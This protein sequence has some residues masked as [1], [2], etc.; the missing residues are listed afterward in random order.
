MARSKAAHSAGIKADDF[1]RI[2]V[3]QRWVSRHPDWAH[4]LR[5]DSIER[6]EWLFTS[7]GFPKN[8]NGAQESAL[9]YAV[10]YGSCGL[11]KWVIKTLKPGINP[12]TLLCAVGPKSENDPRGSII[13]YLQY[14]HNAWNINNLLRRMLRYNRLEVVQYMNIKCIEWHKFVKSSAYT[15]TTNR[16]LPTQKT[17]MNVF[18]TLLMR[19]RDRIGLSP[20]DEDDEYGTA[21]AAGLAF[22]R[23]RATETKAGLQQALPSDV[24]A[25]VSGYDLS[26]LDAV[27]SIPPKILYQ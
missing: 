3:L 23:G 2:V 4:A 12:C 1:E 5:C 18:M 20:V 7:G 22:L 9:D 26:P 24:L 8:E 16:L 15:L 10:R 14:V 17:R 13:L 6:A 21:V 11:V 27:D 25:L 19:L